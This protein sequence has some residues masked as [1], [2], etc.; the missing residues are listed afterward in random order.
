MKCDELKVNITSEKSC[1]KNHAENEEGRVVP[2]LFLL[3][4]KTLYR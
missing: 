1:F 3:S 2:D 4:T